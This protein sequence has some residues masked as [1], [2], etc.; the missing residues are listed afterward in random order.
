MLQRPPVPLAGYF[1]FCF[2]SLDQR[3]RIRI[4]PPARPSG[5]DD[6]GGE[7]DLPAAAAAAARRPGHLRG[8]SPGHGGA[9]LAL[10]LLLEL[11]AHH[12]VVPALHAAE[13]FL[14]AVHEDVPPV[15]RPPAH[16]AARQE[17][18]D[19]ERRAAAG[20][21]GGRA[22]A[23]AQAGG[24]AP[25]APELRHLQP[26]RAPRDGHPRRGLRRA[27]GLE[28]RQ[29]PEPHA[30]SYGVAVAPPTGRRRRAVQRARRRRQAVGLPLGDLQPARHGPRLLHHASLL[31]AE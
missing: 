11:V 8:R 24:A 10:L 18:R 15:Q 9:A 27:L 23:A 6:A 16:V 4:R 1:F 7:E 5:G 25:A 20:P 3:R 22:D 17:L 12:G 31:G 19:A 30:S 14:P 13:G 26:R 2:V 21:G 28:R 29:D